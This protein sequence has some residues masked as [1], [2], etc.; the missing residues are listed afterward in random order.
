MPSDIAARVHGR[1]CS[2]ESY[3]NP[4]AGK[5]L[6]CRECAVSIRLHG[7]V[8][9]RAHTV[10]RSVTS[11]DSYTFSTETRMYSSASTWYGR[12][13]AAQVHGPRPEYRM[14]LIAVN[15]PFMFYVL[16]IGEKEFIAL[17]RTQSLVIE[18]DQFASHVQAM[19]S[20]C[21]DAGSAE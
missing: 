20:Q 9:S 15:D 10:G 6:I 18:F 2:A 12:S 14:E 17:A 19:I 1:T 4:A 11:F 13:Q 3:W 16:N 5:Q 7:T 21:R 8:F